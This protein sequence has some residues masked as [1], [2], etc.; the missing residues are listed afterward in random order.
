MLS[1]ESQEIV[2]LEILAMIGVLLDG[3]GGKIYF[4]AIFLWCVGRRG[5]KTPG[6]ERGNDDNRQDC[7]FWN[8]HHGVPLA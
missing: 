2:A 5:L 6:Q 1:R 7:S 3:V 4:F 8:F